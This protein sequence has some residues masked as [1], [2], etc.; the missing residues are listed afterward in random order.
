M[1]N[2]LRDSRIRVELNSSLSIEADIEPRAKSFR[3]GTSRRLISGVGEFEDGVEKLV[4]ELR[5][6]I[7]LNR[8]KEKSLSVAVSR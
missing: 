4:R 8:K 2:E 3:E 5:D 7:H 1:S 6:S